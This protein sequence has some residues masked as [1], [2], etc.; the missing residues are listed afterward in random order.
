MHA[1]APQP[2]NRCLAPRYPAPN[3]R[4]RPRSSRC[5]PS[6]SASSPG[7][8]PPPPSGRAMSCSQGYVGCKRKH[9]QCRRNDET[10]RTTKPT[11]RY[12]RNDECGKKRSVGTTRPTERRTRPGD[13]TNSTTKTTERRDRH[14]TT[15]PKGR[16]ERENDDT[17]ATAS[18]AERRG[19]RNDKAIGTTRSIESDLPSRRS[20]NQKEKTDPAFNNHSYKCES[21]IVGNSEKRPTEVPH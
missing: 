12:E 14:E 3:K 19:Q 20:P 21:P 8:A 6:E 13:E 15:K 17:N 10:D 9:G 4:P 7:H 5:S 18:S 16:P 11:G 1:P 2:H